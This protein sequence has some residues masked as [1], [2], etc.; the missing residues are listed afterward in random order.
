NGPLRAPEGESGP[1]AL[2]ASFPFDALALLQLPGLFL[3]LVFVL[4]RPP[5]VAVLADGAG[6]QVVGQLNPLRPVA[7]FDAK[8]PALD[9]EIELI[10]CEPTGDGV[11]FRVAVA[12]PLLGD[13]IG[14][15]EAARRV[16]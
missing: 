3:T 15:D 2:P 1:R 12:E 13:E 11:L 14:F 10:L 8:Q 7:F 5:A 9:E 4:R 6:Q 16:G